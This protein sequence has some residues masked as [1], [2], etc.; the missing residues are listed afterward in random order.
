MEKNMS[1]EPKID[2]T[3]QLRSFLLG[4]MQAVADGK[5]DG[6]KAKAICN[7]SQQIYNT[8][9]I[10]VRVA[11]TKASTGKDRLDAVKF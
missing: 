1:N 9:A 5:V 3:A 7:L 11:A 6:S 2:N 4:Q 8:L 10:E